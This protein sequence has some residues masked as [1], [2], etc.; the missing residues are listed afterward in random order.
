MPV[1]VLQLPAAWQE[2]GAVQATW[3]PAVHVPA[4][5]V[6]SRSQELPSLHEAPLETLEYCEVETLGWHV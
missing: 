2:S 6:S 4:W 3:L 5:Q 1:D